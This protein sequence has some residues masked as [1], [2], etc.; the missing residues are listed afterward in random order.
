MCV[1]KY[2]KLEVLRR[3]RCGESFR[4][5]RADD[6]NILADN[7]AVPG[8]LTTAMPQLCY[9]ISRTNSV[10]VDPNLEEQKLSFK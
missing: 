3:L 10:F 7:A 2:Q 5:G 4:L 6:K 1:R 8:F 9:H